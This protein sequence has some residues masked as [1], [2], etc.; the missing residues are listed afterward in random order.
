MRLG[1][2][3]L[4]TSRDERLARNEDFFRSVNERIRE[5]AGK[6]GPDDHV[7]EFICECADSTCTTRVELTSREY[8]RVRTD[9]RRFVIAPG[10]E[11]SRIETV[12]DEGGDHVVVEKIGEAGEIAEALDPR[13]A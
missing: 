13:A 8:E 11:L 7:Y 6:H 4:E 12:V 3:A 9:G 10:H 1:W 5:V 2:G